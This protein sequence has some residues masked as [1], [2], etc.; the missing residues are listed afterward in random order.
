[1]QCLAFSSLAHVKLQAVSLLRLRLGGES[2]GLTPG[3]GVKGSYA[4]RDFTTP[5]GAPRGPFTCSPVRLSTRFCH[6]S[7]APVSVCWNTPHGHGLPAP[8][9]GGRDRQL[10]SSLWCRHFS[11]RGCSS[12]S[13]S[14]SA[15]RQWRGAP[16]RSLMQKGREGGGGGGGGGSIS[17]GGVGRGGGRAGRGAATAVRAGLGDDLGSLDLN[18]IGSARRREQQQ[19]GG[20]K[21]EL[22]LIAGQEKR[23][24]GWEEKPAG[25]GDG[26]GK[27]GKGKGGGSKEAAR[28]PISQVDV[29]VQQQSP[30]VQA[31]RRG[32]GGKTVTVVSGLQLQPS[33]LESLAKALKAQL[34]TGGAV[35]EGEIEIQG[36]HTLKL[37][38]ELTKLGYKAKASGR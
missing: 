31:T 25:A 9:V 3:L 10:S 26:K 21:V 12:S 7:S 20:G 33:S 28:T 4:P 18:F 29:P 34:G 36:E 8:K 19:E 15:P 17:Q 1:M 14:S 27:K 2:S 22:K 11:E 38:A 16:R 5:Y 32:R 6:L 24:F 35:K 37:V 23:Q 13:S 30:I